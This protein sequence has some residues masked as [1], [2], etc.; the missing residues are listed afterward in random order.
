MLILLSGFPASGKSTVAQNYVDQGFFRLNR[1]NV[2]GKVDDLLP[3]LNKLLFAGKNVVMDNTYPTKASRSGAIKVAKDN[4]VKVKSI[5][6]N[7]SFED[8]QFNA[9]LRMIEK[10]GKILNPDE[11]ANDP[12]LFPI[13]VL[14][15]YKKE[16]EKPSIS[17]GFDE[18]EVK[19]F[20]RHYPSNW[21][22]RAAIFDF[23]GTL[24]SHAGKEKFPVMPSEVR[25]IKSRAAK[26]K[27]FEKE[28]YILLGVS[29]QSGIAKGLVT[30]A[31]AIACFD[32]TLNQLGVKFKE[33]LFCPHKVPPISCYCRKPNLGNAVKLIVKYKLSRAESFYVGDMTSDRTFAE[34]SGFKYFDH[35]E[36]WSK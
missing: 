26:I 4:K 15:K 28:G 34:R 7:T 24:R 23:D 21:I 16:F 5:L 36:F 27:E 19:E 8:A 11:H 30:E 22:N 18:V 14:Y 9:C 12:N 20:I 25:A 32:E 17:E 31:N 35:N 33:V 3:E 13:V 2:G 29:N 6:M 1:D 10:T